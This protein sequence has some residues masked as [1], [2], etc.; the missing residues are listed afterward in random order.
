MKVIKMR[1]DPAT[2][3]L[4][5]R[6]EHEGDNIAIVFDIASAIEGRESSMRIA[7]GVKETD[8]AEDIELKIIE[9]PVPPLFATGIIH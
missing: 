3:E 8:T 2:N 1:I 9:V 5:L 4:I 6:C 7:L